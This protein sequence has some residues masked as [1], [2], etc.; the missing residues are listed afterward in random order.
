[1]KTKLNHLE[2]LYK[3]MVRKGETRVVFRANHRGHIFSCIFLSDLQPYRLYV[4]ALG[5]LDLTIEF[6]VSESFFTSSYLKR[7]DFLKLVEYLGIKFNPSSR[8]LTS[9]FLSELDHQFPT[10]FSRRPDYSEVLQ[11][12]TCKMIEDPE[13]V[14]FCG[15]RKSPTGRV[16]V[17]NE[18]K[19]RRAFGDGMA[20]V[21]KRLGISSCWT[22]NRSM[23]AIK[24]INEL[25]KQESI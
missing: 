10:V 22:A 11:L 25:L 23:Q 17:L 20:L 1:M 18:E 3:D 7:E 13:A 21:S 2:K 5:T 12:R 8:F 9:D 4:S 14:Y 16:S 15:W 24:K 6:E 19:T